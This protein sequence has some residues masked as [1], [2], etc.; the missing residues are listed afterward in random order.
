[1]ALV[2]G[3]FPIAR[4]VIETSIDYSGRTLWY[5]FMGVRL[6]TLY[7]AEIPWNKLDLDFECDINASEFCRKGCFNAHFHL[8]VISLWNFTYIPFIV[9]VLLM[10]LFASQLRHNI[11]KAKMKRERKNQTLKHSGPTDVTSQNI[12]NS[13]FVIN[14]HHQKKLLCLY[15]VCIFLRLA[16]EIGFLYVLL[17]H[18]LQKVDG[19]PIK[20]S[21]GLCS[22]TYN[23]VVRGAA[24]KRMSIYMLCTISGVIIGTSVIFALY[25]TC[26]Y[27]LPH[28]R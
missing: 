7:I 13:D 26:H 12:A 22:E 20:C 16:L 28:S 21:T 8:P 17:I 23:C 15:L 2:A 24:E 11:I 4:T 25:Y 19:S 1:M 14:F 5:G 9:S 3:L 10:D 27:L 6:V 18:H